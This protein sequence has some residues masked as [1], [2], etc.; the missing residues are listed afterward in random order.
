[1][2]GWRRAGLGPVD[3]SEGLWGTG[4]PGP[5]DKSEG[6]DWPGLANRSE[7]SGGWAGPAQSGTA[8]PLAD[9]AHRGLARNIPGKDIMHAQLEEKDEEPEWHTPEECFA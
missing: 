4:W 7:G 9:T 3:K 6:L 8:Q 2:R 1:M 5:V